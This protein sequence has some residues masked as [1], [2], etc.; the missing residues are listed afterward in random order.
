MSTEKT[1]SAYGSTS[2][3]RSGKMIFDNSAVDAVSVIV[4]LEF[5]ASICVPC[6]WVCW[7]V[8]Y[9]AQKT[10]ASS[11]GWLGQF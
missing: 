1:K 2:R 3:I 7:G 4:R 6:D 11:G 9:V 5:A 8:R 10:Q